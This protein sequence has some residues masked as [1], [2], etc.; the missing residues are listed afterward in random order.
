MTHTSFSDIT[1]AYERIS[2]IV[3]RTPIMQSAL[4][5]TWLGHDIFLR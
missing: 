3:Q 4:L 5:N 1:H 2:S